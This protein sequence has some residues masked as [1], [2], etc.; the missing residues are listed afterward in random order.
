MVLGSSRHNHAVDR[1]SFGERNLRLAL[2]DTM[3]DRHPQ[4]ERID[5]YYTARPEVAHGLLPFTE[6]VLAPL[7][8]FRGQVPTKD[9]I[10]A[11]TLGPIP[12]P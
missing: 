7:G 10:R 1:G 2:S 3:A 5:A 9:G 4:V 8:Q 11:G 6:V 12:E